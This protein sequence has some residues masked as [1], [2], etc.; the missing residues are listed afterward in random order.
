[1]LQGLIFLEVK[2]G[3]L[4]FIVSIVTLEGHT[5]TLGGSIL[6]KKKKKCILKCQK[7]CMEVFFSLMEGIR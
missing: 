4:Q 2:G 6:G 5:N 3:L 7:A 1:M